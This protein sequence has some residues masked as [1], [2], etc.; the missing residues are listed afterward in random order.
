MKI[1]LHFTPYLIDYSVITHG[2]NYLLLVKI[3][4]C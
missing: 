2:M 4:V 1:T 3:M